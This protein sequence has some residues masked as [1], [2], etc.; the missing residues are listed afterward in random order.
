MKDSIAVPLERLGD[1]VQRYLHDPDARLLHVAIDTHLRSGGLRLVLASEHLADN[2]SPW[3]CVAY[4]ARGDAAW[5]ELE[6]RLVDEHEALRDAGAPMVPL[7]R[8]LAGTPGPA[9][10]AA[11]LVQCE[12]TVRAPARG[13]FV[14]LVCPPGTPAP[15]WLDQLRQLIV[16]P[17][18]ARVRFVLLSAPFEAASWHAGLPTGV[19]AFHECVVD[20]QLAQRELAEEIEAEERLGPGHEG[21]WPRDVPIP[22]PAG[23][24][25]I[26][27]PACAA[28]DPPPPPATKTSSNPASTSPPGGDSVRLCIKRAV[29]ARQRGDR[30]QTI[31][32]QL[33]A[34]DLC[35]L[36][37]NPEDAIRMEL[38]LGGYLLEFDDRAHAHQAFE[39]A[40]HQ[41]TQHGAA[42]L[43]AQAHYAR[44]WTWRGQP[45]PDLA[46]RS[47]MAGVEAAKR[48]DHLALV[49]EGYWEAGDL[50]L[51]LQQRSSLVSLWTEAIRFAGMHPWTRL[52]GTRLPALAERLAEVLRRL[53]RTKDARAVAAW[54]SQSTGDDHV[55]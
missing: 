30:A 21:A 36:D 49:F 24:G 39:R 17:A 46:L 10:F 6:D 42:G 27:L 44:A 47:Y 48:G 14:V 26:T 34:R 28:N 31:A 51:E 1:A 45:E 13:L 19:V 32:Q 38:I 11:R 2:R 3:M 33:R 41:A 40:A 22:A 7:R 5:V 20:P 53:H 37:G 25:R 9:R 54:A 16:A 4:Q 43:E 50:L 35:V 55:R 23:S 8:D 15:R 12:A 29:L 52:R 18:L